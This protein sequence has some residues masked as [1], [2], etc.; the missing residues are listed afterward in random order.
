MVHKQ[1]KIDPIRAEA[2]L[3]KMKEAETQ[4]VQT[5]GEFWAKVLPPGIRDELRLEEFGPEKG[6]L[7]RYGFIGKKD[8]MYIGSVN[9]KG[10]YRVRRIG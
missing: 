1:N 6:K 4:F 9:D 3:E 10:K 7:P 2:L 8:G 5:S